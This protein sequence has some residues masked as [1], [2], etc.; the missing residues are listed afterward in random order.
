VDWNTTNIYT[1]PRVKMKRSRMRHE[2]CKTPLI[3]E[4]N[5][6]GTC[7]PKLKFYSFK[8]KIYFLLTSVLSMLSRFTHKFH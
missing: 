4:K 6:I 7:R 5:S 3:A 2:N 8:M 1:L